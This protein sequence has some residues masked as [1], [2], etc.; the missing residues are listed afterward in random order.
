MEYLCETTSVEGFVQLLAC[1]YLP[2]GYW[3]YVTG[4][5]PEGKDPRQV[6]AKL[7]G[8]YGIAVS[9]AA[10][11]RR[12]QL[13]YAN[14]QYLRH[15]RFFVILATHGKH[16]FFEDE[17]AGLRDV[18]RVPLKFAGY[19]ISY[20]RGG[21]ARDG[22]PDCKWHSHVE[23]DRE[24]YKVLRAWFLDTAVRRSA[25]KVLLDFYRFPFEPYAPVRQQML[26]LLRA[27]NNARKRAGQEQIPYKAIPLHRRVV[28]PFEPSRILIG[29]DG[30][31]CRPDGNAVAEAKQRG[32]GNGD[33]PGP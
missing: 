26:N 3:L 28:R 27:V 21:R 4:W 19:S 23:I 33:R 25:E 22:S 5:I 8:K 16:R 29:L 20:R 32:G 12:K 18:R 14:L 2:H 1:N 7:I 11:S 30:G 24:W 17:A 9:R 31:K 6:D 13:G 10:R 15:G